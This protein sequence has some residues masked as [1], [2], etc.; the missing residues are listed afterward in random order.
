MAIRL[1]I[2]TYRKAGLSLEEFRAHYENHANLI[3]RLTGDTFPLSHRRTYIA[4]TTANTPPEDATPR[5]PTTPATVLRGTQ[6]EF[7]FDATAELTFENQSAY[8]RFIARV[9]NPEIAAQIAADE[10]HFLERP[11][12]GIAMIGEVADTRR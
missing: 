9:G 5:N 11:T 8:D 1:L 6:A 10:E 7:D 12:V 2:I 3:K 4:R